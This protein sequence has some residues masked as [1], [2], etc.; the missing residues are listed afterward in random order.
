MSKQLPFENPSNINEYYFEI[1]KRLLKQKAID[2]N[3]ICLEKKDTNLEFLQKVLETI[4][5]TMKTDKFINECSLK[6]L[7]NSSDQYENN[8]DSQKKSSSIQVMSFAMINLYKTLPCPR[9]QQC[10]GRPREIA[11]YNQYSDEELSCVFYH[12]HK[13]RRRIAITPRIRD[14]F[15]Y[16][17]NYDKKKEIPNNAKYSRNYFESIYHPIYYKLFKCK[18]VGCNQSYYCP[19][20]HNE[21]EKLLWD[22]IF[23]IYFLKKR[24]M[25]TGKNFNSPLKELAKT[26]FEADSYLQCSEGEFVTQQHHLYPGEM[27]FKDIS[28]WNKLSD[29]ECE[30]ENEEEYDSTS[31]TNESNSLAQSN[32]LNCMSSSIFSNPQTSMSFI[33]SS[34]TSFTQL[35]NTDNLDN[36]SKELIENNS[37]ILEKSSR[38]LS[39]DSIEDDYNFPA[40][41]PLA[42]SSKNYEIKAEENCG[43]L[44]HY[45]DWEK[46]KSIYSI[47]F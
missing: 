33:F 18:R 3:I 45:F 26:T 30:G 36:L 1:L 42:S 17:A 22:E 20:N 6:E 5:S 21:V 44:G 31:T 46:I 32:S 11:P 47:Q 2:P 14:E 9:H 8:P 16:K 7:L 28:S 25:Y 19:F 4:F 10:K 43:T 37:K 39:T 34:N 35:P 13:D 41:L 38:K 15:L 27:K 24:E 40:L 29:S 23:Q 12:H